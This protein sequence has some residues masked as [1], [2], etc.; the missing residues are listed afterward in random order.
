MTAVRKTLT[1]PEIELVDMFAGHGTELM[2]SGSSPTLDGAETGL[3][4]SGSAPVTLTSMTDGVLTGL[5]T[6]GA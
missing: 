2:P 4:P 3:F 5:F 1:Q 6:A